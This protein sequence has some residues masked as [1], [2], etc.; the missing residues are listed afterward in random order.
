MLKKQI[1]LQTNNKNQNNEKI[2]K[3]KQIN[4]FITIFHF[5]KALLL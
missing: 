4:K 3:T 5:L 2:S 1:I